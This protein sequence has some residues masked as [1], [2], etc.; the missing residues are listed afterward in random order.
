MKKFSTLALALTLPMVMSLPAGAQ[1]SDQATAIPVGVQ[2]QFLPDAPDK[3]VVVRGDTLWG[4]AA[5]FL[6]NP[7]CWPEVWGMNKEEIRNP[8]WIYP[9]QIVYFDRVNG[10]LRL[11]TPISTSQAAETEPKHIKLSPQIRS[12]VTHQQ[13][14]IAAIPNNL[15]EPYL[16]QPLIIEK[17]EFS[18]T[19]RIVAA[20]EGRV[21]LGKGDKVYVRGDLKGGNSF[22]VFRQGVPLR[23]PDNREVIGYEAM[24]IGTVK[25]EKSAKTPD[26]VDTFVVVSSKEEMG[27]GDRL[28]PLPPSPIINYVPHRADSKVTARVVAVYGGVSVAGQ[29]NI[30]SINRGAASGVNV[31]TVFELGRYGKMIQDRTNDKKLVRMPD[32]MYGQLFIF[33]V[34]KN[35]SYGLVMQVTDVVNVG[36]IVRPPEK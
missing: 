11:G 34:F 29:N 6:Q 36:D 1:T 18:N 21:Y 12:E 19:P 3:H 22:Q 2:C 31:G 26:G 8:H 30:V 23:D 9:N 10:R 13:S 7:W 4:I 5:R 17:D 32:E 14:A 15:I 35:I 33:R 24:Y 25:L 27:I 16:S 28:V 20:Q